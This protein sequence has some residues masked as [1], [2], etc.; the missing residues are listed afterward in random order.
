MPL[1]LPLLLLHGVLAVEPDR[2]YLQRVGALEAERQALGRR[3]TEAAPE[4][5]QAVMTEA[6]TLVFRRF[7]DELLP[8]WQGTPWDFWGTSQ[9]PGQG[10]IACG[11]FV[12]T[13]LEDAGF[14]VE[15]VRMAQQASEWIIRSLAP[16]DRTWRF[17]DRSVE[18]SLQPLERHGDGLYLAGLDCHVGFL[19]R[20]GGQVRFCDSSY[21]DPQQVTCQDPTEAFS[22]TSRYRVIG[23]LLEDPMMEAW[24]QGDAIPTYLGP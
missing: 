21:L 10:E 4:Q 23:R 5:R 19:V 18:D 13:L 15:R 24:L 20:D 17:S 6:R 16:R 7:V 2:D 11:Y 8:A 1:L 12:S 9:V 14:R 3:W 22:Y